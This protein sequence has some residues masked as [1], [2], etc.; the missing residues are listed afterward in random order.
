MKKLTIAI[1]G[2]FITLVILDS[3]TT[4]WAVSI[5]F[6]ESSPLWRPISHTYWL[7]PAVI[8]PPLVIGILIIRFG[9]R[10][11]TVFALLILG[12]LIIWITLLVQTIIHNAQLISIML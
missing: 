7:F 4:F 1:V 9:E 5:G 6:R 3:V 12:G 10:I 8:L 11:Q 2:I